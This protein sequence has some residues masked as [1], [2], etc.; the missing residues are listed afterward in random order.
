MILMCVKE[1]VQKQ[2][3]NNNLVF[4]HCSGLCSY[5]A[6]LYTVNLW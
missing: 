1:T 6:D 4:I 3:H 5:V 2:I